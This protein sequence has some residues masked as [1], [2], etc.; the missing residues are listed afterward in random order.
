MF[1]LNEWLSDALRQILYYIECLDAEVDSWELKKQMQE[2]KTLFSTDKQ[3][4]K[5]AVIGVFTV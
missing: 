3:N 2:L 1:D 4:E 5:S